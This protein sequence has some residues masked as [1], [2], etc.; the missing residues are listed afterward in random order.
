MLYAKVKNTHVL[1]FPFTWELLLAENP[2]TLFD[3]QF[4]LVNWYAKTEAAT[5]GSSVVEVILSS[6][7]A[8]IDW[9]TQIADRAEIPIFI[10]GIWELSWNVRPKTE[11]ELEAT[12]TVN[13]TGVTYNNHIN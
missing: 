9:A 7:P 3:N 4:D 6:I 12:N 11:E 2:N 5:D 13:F 1:E 10:N 8:D